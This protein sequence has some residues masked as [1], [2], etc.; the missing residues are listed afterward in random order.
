VPS[1]N[2]IAGNAFYCPSSDL[3]AW[4]N[5]NLVPGLYDEFGAFTLGIVFAHEF[6]HAV[7]RRSGTLDASIRSELQADCFAGAW[8]RSADERGLLDEGEI[9]EALNAATAV[10]DDRI[11]AQAGQPVNPES[12]THGTSE[13]RVSW[14]RRG[15]D[16]ADP[17]RCTTFQEL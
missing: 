5:V 8:A 16:T 11:Q 7:Q 15:Y 2:E 17:R 1:Y 9:S 13:Q 10:G 14:F 3:I 12:F 6:A 4:D